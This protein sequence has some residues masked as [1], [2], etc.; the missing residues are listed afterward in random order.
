[1]TIAFDDLVAPPTTAEVRAGMYT[2][3]DANG[4]STTS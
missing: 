4:C 2:W 1:M 3:L